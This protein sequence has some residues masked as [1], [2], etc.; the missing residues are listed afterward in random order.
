M[1]VGLLLASAAAESS[2][3]VWGLHRT[4]WHLINF[5]IFAGFLVFLLRRPLG[6]YLAERKIRITK[7]MEEAKKFRTEMEQKFLVYEERLKSID[8]QVQKVI[9]DT[10][11]EAE[12]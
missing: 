11:A 7:E 5:V 4:V 9:D 3:I 8:E 10:K 12:V 6:A 2:N 1:S